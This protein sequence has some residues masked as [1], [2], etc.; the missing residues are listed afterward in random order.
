MKV[1][2]SIPAGSG[3]DRVMLIVSSAD[4]EQFER[5][6]LVAGHRQVERAVG[7]GTQRGG[8]TSVACAPTS[9]EKS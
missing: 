7:L 4:G 5:R 8:P 9:G 6:V 1:A 2:V 3:V